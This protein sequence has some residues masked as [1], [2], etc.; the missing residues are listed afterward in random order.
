MS[1]NSRFKSLRTMM[2]ALVG[3]SCFSVSALGYVAVYAQVIPEG[4]PFDT[5]WAAITDLQ[6]EVNDLDSKTDELE[7][8]DV[9]L[10][11]EIENIELIPG[12]AGPEGPQGEQGPIGPQGEKGERGSRGPDGEQGPVGPAGADGSEARVIVTKDPRT[13]CP[14]PSIA[15]KD[16]FAQKISISKDGTYVLISADIV[17]SYSGMTE[18]SLFVDGS[19]VDRTLTQTSSRVWS[20][21]HVSWGGT[22]DEGDHTISIRSPKAGVWGCGPDYGS[23]ITTIFE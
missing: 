17:R 19:A 3:L 10:W 5:I 11:A 15:N 18:L 8:A 20:D 13:Q 23:I 9:E 16:I 12:P 1:A 7:E 22:L 2:V 6:D 14:A 21:V 4:E